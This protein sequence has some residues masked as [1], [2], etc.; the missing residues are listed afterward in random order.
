MMKLFFFEFFK[1]FLRLTIIINI[2]AA[3][4]KTFSIQQFFQILKLYIKNFD[5]RHK[6][7]FCEY[8]INLYYRNRF[9]RYFLKFL[10]LNLITLLIKINSFKL[11]E[12]RIYKK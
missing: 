11:Y 4:S 5:C 2:V 1:N 9:R 10:M 7:T 3:I 6:F 8:V 12:S